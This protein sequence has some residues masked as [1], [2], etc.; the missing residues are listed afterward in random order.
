VVLCVRG[1]K[2]GSLKNWDAENWVKLCKLLLNMNFTPVITGIKESV[3]FE[4]PDGCIELLNQTTIE[5]LIAIMQKSIFVVGQSTGPMHLA[6]LSGVPHTVWG[7]SR[8]RDR[9]LNSWNPHRTL[10]EYYTCKNEDN[11][12]ASTYEEIESLINRMVKRLGIENAHS[13]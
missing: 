1:R 2:F 12:F 11:Q 4:P 6:A 3:V 9:Y 13:L 8:L 10:V 7:S 5:D